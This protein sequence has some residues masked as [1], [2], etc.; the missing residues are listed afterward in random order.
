MSNI[1]KNYLI[2][3]FS[4]LFLNKF[5]D[6]KSSKLLLIKSNN[7]NKDTFEGKSVRI[8]VQKSISVLIKYNEDEFSGRKGIR[9]DR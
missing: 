7:R 2:I 6:S 9:S 5:I 8:I 4:L 3:S 1:I